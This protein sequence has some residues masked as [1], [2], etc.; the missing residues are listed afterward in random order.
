MKNDPSLGDPR[1]QLRGHTNDYPERRWQWRVAF[2]LLLAIAAFYLFTEH[3]AHLALGLPYLPFLLLAACPL[4]HMFGHGGHGGYDGHRHSRQHRSGDSP[5]PSSDARS[6]ATEHRTNGT[7][8]R[9]ED[10]P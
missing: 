8:R 1:P 5:S 7:H 6:G 2:W 9:E 10:R 4:L 3:R